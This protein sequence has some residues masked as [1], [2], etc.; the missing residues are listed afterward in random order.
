MHLSS[1]RRTN[2]KHGCLCGDLISSQHSLVPLQL[3]LYDK[4][5]KRVYCENLGDASMEGPSLITVAQQH[6]YP[7]G[8]FDVVPA[9]KVLQGGYPMAMRANSTDHLVMRQVRFLKSF[10]MQ[11]YLYSRIARWKGKHFGETCNMFPLPQ[12]V[13]LHPK[14]KLLTTGPKN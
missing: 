3:S 8:Y 1:N 14:V 6:C 11:N 7:A 9:A 10:L 4:S 12:G 2:V 5:H 13:L